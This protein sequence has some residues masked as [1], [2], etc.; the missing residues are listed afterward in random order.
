MYGAALSKHLWGL[1]FQV[2]QVY[3]GEPRDPGL[4]SHAGRDRPVRAGMKVEWMVF[5]SG[6][7]NSDEEVDSRS[8]TRRA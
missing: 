3:M 4:I 2:L 6:W 7:S 5:S 1:L 8:V